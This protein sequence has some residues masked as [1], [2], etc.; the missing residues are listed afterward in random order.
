MT[1]TVSC[2]SG[3]LRSANSCSSV[4]VLDVH[5]VMELFSHLESQN[6]GAAGQSGERK[7]APPTP[8]HSSPHHWLRTKHSGITLSGTER[9]RTHSREP[10]RHHEIIRVGRKN[11]DGILLGEKVNLKRHETQERRNSEQALS[12]FLLRSQSSV[13]L[14]MTEW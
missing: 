9:Q 11:N 6:W 4:T 8:R 14:L 13:Y 7:R 3:L 1:S 5:H 10:S 2:W 12:Q